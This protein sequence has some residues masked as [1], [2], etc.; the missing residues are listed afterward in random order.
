MAPPQRPARFPAVAARSLTGVDRHLPVEFDGRLVVA[1]LAFRQA[2]QRLVDAWAPHL[3]ELV[4]RTEGLRWFELPVL[5]RQWAPLRP[6]ID[7]GMARGINDP[8]VN[9]RT[10]TIYGDVGRVCDPLHITDRSTITVVL[11]DRSGQ[12]HW[13]ATGGPT[14]A[15]VA[16]LDDTVRALSPP[17]G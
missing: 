3:D 10:L 11:T 6:F 13:R 17:A 5:G 12:V 8:V 16:A 2:Q 14:T 4:E 1:V 15:S 9:A 7:G